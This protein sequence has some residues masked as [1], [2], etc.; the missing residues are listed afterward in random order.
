MSLIKDTMDVKYPRGVFIMFFVQLLSMIGF[1]FVMYLLVLYCTHSL[2]LDDQ[3][4]YALTGAYVALMYAT[5][6]IGGHIGE[7]YFGYKRSVVSGVTIAAFGLFLLYIKSYILLIFGLAIFIVGSGLFI[8][9]SFVLLGRIYPTGSFFRETGF[10][11]SYIGMNVGSFFAC[12][13]AGP[14]QKYFDFN[15]VFLIGGICQLLLLFY[16]LTYRYVFNESAPDSISARSY[17][18]TKSNTIIGW[19]WNVVTVVLVTILLL[20]PSFCNILLIFVGVLS[21]AF[22]IACASKERGIVKRNLY[23]FLILVSISLCFW[24]LYMLSGSALMLFSDRN[25]DR[26][27]L[28]YVIPTAS[29]SA[30]NPFFIMAIGPLL[31]IFW[32]FIH[33]VF[34]IEIS[35]PRKF[36]FGLIFMGIGFLVLVFGIRHANSLGLISLSWLIYSYFFQTIGELLVGPVGFSMVGSLVPERME[37]VMMGIWEL[38]S[39]LA[40]I[41]SAYLAQ[42]TYFKNGQDLLSTNIDYSH[43]FLL[44]GS[45]IIII[46]IIVT[47]FSPLIKK[48]T[49]R[50]TINNQIDPRAELA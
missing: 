18:K 16:F 24:S 15:M 10:M 36:S 30:L 32:P 34:G 41:L 5:H 37:G 40:G 6:I 28:G 27:I 3:H 7:R 48:L 38:A 31:G 47:I 20:Y 23:A 49:T 11:I 44:Y 39:G 29:L 25:I 17:I 42:K 50:D 8:P 22:I 19:L 35:I 14:L 46:G 2:H 9:C 1:S 43:Q 12:A 33:R 26:N 21:A 45:I 13:L 4:A